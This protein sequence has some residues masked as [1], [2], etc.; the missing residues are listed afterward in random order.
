[1]FHH[2]AVG[3]ERMHFYLVGEDGCVAQYGFRLIHLGTGKVRNADVLCQTLAL[4]I[5]QGTQ[6]LLHG[7]FVTGRWPVDQR[8]IHMVGFEPCEAVMEAVDQVTRVQLVVPD[9]GGQENFPA[10]NTTGGNAITNF[11]FVS[12]HLGSID[13]AV[14]QGQSALDGIT[15]VVALEPERS[16]ADL[17][18]C[19]E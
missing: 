2:L 9:F 13:M 6:I 1:M 5:P 10:R 4:G 16:H 7:H 17:R 15:G 19:A 8:Q 11:R 12:I 3:Q 18:K 14:A